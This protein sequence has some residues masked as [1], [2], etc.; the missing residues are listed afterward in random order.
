MLTSFKRIF[1]FGWKNFF[2]NIG[3]SVATCFILTL[4]ILLL[5][6]LFLL[7][8]AANY[9]ISA[10]QEKA[11]ITAFLKEDVPEEDILKFRGELLENPEVKKVDYVSKQTALESFVQKHK[12][13]PQLMKAITLFENPFLAHL[14]I[15]AFEARQYQDI[16]D[17]LQNS[18][19]SNSI[20]E[21]N[22][23]KRE[24][25]IDQIFTVTGNIKKAGIGAGIILAIIA[26]LVAFNTVRLAIY[27]MREEIRI[28]KLVG[29]SNWFTRGPFL[30]QGLVSGIFAALFSL[31]FT[32]AVL[33]FFA[34]RIQFFLSGFDIMSYFFTNLS[35]L[36]LIQFATG[37][38]LGIIS[39]Y[40]AV[41]KYLKV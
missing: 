36:L 32:Y 31:L 23:V 3:L 16:V 2:N 41:R 19:F 10:V 13:E 15:K 27:N 39:S 21:I 4:V 11:D 5:T 7:R 1:Y 12:D 33:Y 28:Q 14:N 30:I 35:T 9:L 8:G 24:S 20:E 29:A 40:I 18:S 22:Y 25:I 6:S 17:F 38:A 37:A 26:V 34:P